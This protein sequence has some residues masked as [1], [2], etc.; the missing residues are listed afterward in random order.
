MLH[1]FANKHIVEPIFKYGVREIIFLIAPDKIDYYR[2]HIKEA[3][4]KAFENLQE[5]KTYLKAKN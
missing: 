1:G 5:V 2:K 4:I 3:N